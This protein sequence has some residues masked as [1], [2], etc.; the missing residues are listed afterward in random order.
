MSV[1]LLAHHMESPAGRGHMPVG[2]CTGAA[3]GAACGDLVRVSVA[4]DRHSDDG[5]IV[6]AGFDASGCGAAIAAGSAVVEITHAATL[7][8]AARIG[9][10]QIAAELGGLSPAKHHAAELAADALHRALGLAARESATLAPSRSRALVGMR[11]GVGR[12]VAALLVG[13]GGD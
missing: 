8:E 9:P 11:G 6:D 3:G 7:L 2:A 10:S 12:A 4:I 5:R 13:G 1:E